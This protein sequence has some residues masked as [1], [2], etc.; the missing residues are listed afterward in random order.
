MTTLFSANGLPATPLRLLER[1]LR[2]RQRGHVDRVDLELSEEPPD[3]L[4]L[5]L[6]LVRQARFVA[7][8]L[9]PAVC[10]VICLAVPQ[11]QPAVPQNL[12]VFRDRC[13]LLVLGGLVR[14]DGASACETA[15]PL[16][17]IV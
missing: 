15:P 16:E 6:A 7:G 3:R 10:V 17:M 12:A 1:L 9:H 11:Q 4:R 2:A 14:R 5:P 8:S 13:R